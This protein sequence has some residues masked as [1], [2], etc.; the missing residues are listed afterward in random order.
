MGLDQFFY[1]GEISDEIEVAYFRKHW[2]LH[3]EIQKIV[4]HEIKNC[5]SVLLNE[6]QLNKIV[7]FLANDKSYWLLEHK[8]IHGRV[9]IEF[10]NSLGALRYYKK[11][12]YYPSW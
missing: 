7:D 6:N 10:I 3:E 5:T 11:V 9:S 4:G 1:L 12:V 8:D 2:A